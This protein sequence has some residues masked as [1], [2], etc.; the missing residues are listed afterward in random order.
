MTGPDG[1]RHLPGYLAPPLQAELA[2]QIRA[3][4][5]AAPL[6]TPTMP[7][8]GKPFSVR[9]TNCGALG[10]VSDKSGG[11]RY[12]ADASHHRPALA[13]HAEDAARYLGRRGSLPRPARGLSSQP[14]W[15]RRQDGVAPRRGRAGPGGTG[16]LDLARR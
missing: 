13:R 15:A 8:T 5:A 4:V 11:Y 2:S 7:R 12:Q 10:W 3:I 1:F 9:M 6:Y 14:L 16:G